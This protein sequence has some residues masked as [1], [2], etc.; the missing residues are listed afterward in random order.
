MTDPKLVDDHKRVIKLLMGD[1]FD[2]DVYLRIMGAA[3]MVNG[4]SEDYF[5]GREE[6]IDILEKRYKKSVT[7]LKGDHQE[8]LVV[9]NM[10]PGT[11]LSSNSFS[12]AFGGIQAFG[13]DVWRSMEIAQKILPRPDQEE[14]RQRFVMARVMTT[15][16]TLMALTDGTQKLLIRI[17]A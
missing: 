14:D 11:T 8:C 15:V 3:V 17:P 12:N 10:V 16:A 2:R 7:T 4:R 1:N 6:I 9:V 5:K 13:Y